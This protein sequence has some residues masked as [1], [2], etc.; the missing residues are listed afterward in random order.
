V[1][2]TPEELEKYLGEQGG[3][4]NASGGGAEAAE[5]GQPDDPATDGAWWPLTSVSSGGGER[6]EKARQGGG[7]TGASGLSEVFRADAEAEEA[8]LPRTDA[9]RLAINHD[10]GAF[11]F[12]D[13]TSADSVEGFL[14]GWDVRRLRWAEGRIACL[15]R[16]GKRGRLIDGTVVEC[17]HCTH[18]VRCSQSVRLYFIPSP[19]TRG[20]FYFDVP[21]GQVGTFVGY[22]KAVHRETEGRGEKRPVYAVVTRV[23]LEKQQGRRA[24][25]LS[26]EAV[27]LADAGEAEEVRA[28]REELLPY[29]REEED[30][31]DARVVAKLPSLEDVVF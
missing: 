3:T 1:K 10:T 12:P 7:D 24:A 18:K 28:L 25:R 11:E 27:R 8:A 26:F 23:R 5:A 16:D 31:G 20:L 29:A 30:G 22:V 2:V 19:V 6:L 15:S 9:F 4:G 14:V 13:G 21:S 17:E